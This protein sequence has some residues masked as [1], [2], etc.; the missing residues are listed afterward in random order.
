MTALSVHFTQSCFSCIFVMYIRMYLVVNCHLSCDS[1]FL[2]PHSPSFSWCWRAV[3]RMSR[4]PTWLIEIL[5]TFL[6]SLITWGT[7]S[8]SLTGICHQKV[9]GGV[10][11][12]VCE[13]VGYEPFVCSVWWVVGSMHAS[14]HTL[15]TCGYLDGAFLHYSLLNNKPMPSISNVRMYMQ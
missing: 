13:G 3:S 10:R 2:P 1:F 4:M 9:C 8:S 14:K 5:A 11:G 12:Y 7:A 15:C 6:P